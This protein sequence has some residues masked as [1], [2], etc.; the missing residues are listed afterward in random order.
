MKSKLLDIK[1]E[2]KKEGEVSTPYILEL[3]K[4]EKHLVC[5]GIKHIGSEGYSD[6]QFRSF[7]KILEKLKPKIILVERVGNNFENL[8]GEFGYFIPKAQEKNIEVRGIDRNMLGAILEVSNRF[9][10]KSIVLLRALARL[11]RTDIRPQIKKHVSETLE[12]ISSE[13][14]F[15]EI[16]RESGLNEESFTEYLEEYI[17]VLLGK[18]LNELGEDDN[19][20]PSPIDEKHS[21]NKII[22]EVSFVRDTFMLKNL[23]KTLEKYD[24]V[25]YVLG[26]NHIVRQEKVIEELFESSCKN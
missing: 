2:I 24:R 26:K 25:L 18:G 9:E 22:R 4:K 11:T 7:D 21:L 12:I 23:R 5:L 13:K 16:Y 3:R 1:E 10:P 6:E 14:K 19:I 20:F 8:Q 15:S 17:Q